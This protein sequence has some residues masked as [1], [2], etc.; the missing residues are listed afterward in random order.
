MKIIR[1]ENYIYIHLIVINYY[2]RYI[3]GNKYHLNTTFNL[4]ILYDL[5]LTVKIIDWMLY[6]IE[7]Y[8]RKDSLIYKLWNNSEIFSIKYV[9]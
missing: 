9:V 4:Y 3:N 1:N 5:L 8:T 6:K 7:Y 2:K